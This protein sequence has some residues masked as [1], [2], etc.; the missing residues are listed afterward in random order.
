MKWYIL[1]LTCLVASG[2]FKENWKG[3]YYRDKENLGDESKWVI[4]PGEFSSLSDCRDW[5]NGI[6]RSRNDDNYDYECG[7]DCRF[8]KESAIFVCKE[9]VR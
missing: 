5:V 1:A 4:S 8:N 6:V 9:T 3:F 7:K 2:C